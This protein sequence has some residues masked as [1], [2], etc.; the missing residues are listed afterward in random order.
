MG[1]PQRQDGIKIRIKNNPK[2]GIFEKLS[3]LDLI[4]TTF[5]LTNKL[6]LQINTNFRTGLT[7]KKG[8][9]FI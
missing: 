5:N 4:A 9:D 8:W 2:K 1:R 7:A 3:F 6:L